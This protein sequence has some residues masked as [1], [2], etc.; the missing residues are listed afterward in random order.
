M[1]REFKCGNRMF[2]NIF[3]YFVQ[4]STVIG[5][6]FQRPVL[7]IRSHGGDK[8]PEQKVKYDAANSRTY[9]AHDPVFRLKD[10]Q[11]N[12]SCRKTS[13]NCSL[14]SAA[15]MANMIKGTG[16]S[17]TRYQYAKSKNVVVRLVAW[18]S[19]KCIQAEG[20]V[21]EVRNAKK[22]RKSVIF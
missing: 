15:S 19:W 12:S 3:Q 11:D 5:E 22:E 20:G 8:F 10:P 16:C 13:Q 14:P 4:A 6:I 18:K 7:F 17:A 21:Q 2:E 9:H 1:K